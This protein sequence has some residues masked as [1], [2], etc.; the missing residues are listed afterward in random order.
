MTA[1]QRMQETRPKP[2]VRC[3]DVM[4]ATS[5]EAFE[6]LQLKSDI[7]WALKQILS[8]SH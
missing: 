6:V 2:S 3:W 7:P 1:S 5:Q 8:D 4:D